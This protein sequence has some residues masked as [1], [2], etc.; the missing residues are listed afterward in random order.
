MANYTQLK[1]DVRSWLNRTDADVIANIPNF[2][3]LAE[4]RICREC[5]NI[6]LVEYVVSDLSLNG[7]GFVVGENVIPKPTG[8]RKPL[9]F[10][11]L[12][13]GVINQIKLRD[14]EVLDLYWPND[15]LTGLPKYYADADINYLKVAPTPDQ[16]YSYKLGYLQ[17]PTPLSNVNQNNWLTDYIYDI[18]LY[19]SLIA[20]MP[21]IKT[22]ERLPMWE[23]SYNR[24]IEILNRQ[25]KTRIVD[26][27]SNREAD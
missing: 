15:G 27:A 17:Y 3:N 8:W 9:S 14:I 21:Y 10:T 19:G 11:V 26:K 25:D 12:S 13:G 16:A 23:A 20:A 24:G 7:G 5:E 18:L 6:G 4:L 1:A 2:I 22:D